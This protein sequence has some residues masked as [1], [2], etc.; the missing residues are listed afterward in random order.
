MFD[1]GK[2]KDW[3][4]A[5]VRHDDI[6]IFEMTCPFT[7]DVVRSYFQLMS[8]YESDIK[9]LALNHTRTRITNLQIIVKAIQAYARDHGTYPLSPSF[10][11]IYFTQNC[12]YNNWIPGLVPT[13]IESLPRD[14][15][16]DKNPSHQYLYASDGK[17]FKII[18]HLPEDCLSVK[19]KYPQLVDPVRSP[20][21]AYGYWTPDAKNW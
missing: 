6:S 16:D 7:E 5:D 19:S 3:K 4:F 17:D 21:G 2:A 11:G 12:L 14:P 9:I 20:C 10:S 1:N 15:R 13:Y 8:A 18:S